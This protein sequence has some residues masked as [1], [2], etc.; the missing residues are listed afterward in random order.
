MENIG[1]PSGGP[2]IS[3][4]NFSTVAITGGRTIRLIGQRIQMGGGTLIIGPEANVEGIALQ[5]LVYGAGF[6]FENG[7]ASVKGDPE[8][9]VDLTIRG[10]D[11]LNVPEGTSL[12]VLEGVTLTVDG[13]LTVEGEL[14]GAGAIRVETGGS[15]TGTGDISGKVQHKLTED[16]VN[17]EKDSYTYTGE[18]ITPEV[19]INEYTQ[20]TDYMVTYENNTDAG[21]ATITITPTKTGKLYGEV[22][23]YFT[24]SQATPTFAEDDWKVESKTYDGEQISITVPALTGVNN[25]PI[26]EN[27]TLRYKVAGQ[28][29]DTY[30]EEAPT[31]VGEYVVKATFAGNDNY[32]EAETTAQFTI[33]KASATLEYKEAAITKQY[34]DAAFVN[35][36]TNESGVQVSYSSSDEMVATVDENGEVTIHAVGET[37]ITA[38]VNDPNYTGEATY[39]LEVEAGEVEISRPDEQEQTITL[40]AGGTAFTLT[41][42]ITGLP[43]SE[44][45]RKWKWVSSDTDIATVE[46]IETLSTRA[47]EVNTEIKSEALVTPVGEGT[48]TITVTYES[49]NYKGTLTYTVS[50]KAKEE[51][52]APKPDPQPDPTPLYYNIQFGDICEGVDASLSKGVVKEGN[53][54]SVYVEVE[55]GYD[56]ENLKVLFKRSLYGYWEEVEEGVQPGEYII[57]NVYTDIYVKVV[58]VEKIEIEEEPTGMSDI[59]GTKVYAQNGSLYVYTSQPQEVMIITMNGTILKRERQEGLR[60][61]SLPKGVYIICIGEERMKVRN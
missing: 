58:G 26:T 46:E 3:G 60:S 16:M 52:P 53:Q 30:T 15:I 12:T 8:L 9:P 41:A 54:V 39:T 25:E 43:D 20:D 42:T 11:K 50:V 37:T 22:T 5:S 44:Q 35:E 49:T 29:D 34:G 17:I 47:E 14:K 1:G 51:E 10:E 48:A 45:N 18:A 32:N 27:I 28:D 31:N 19:T 56:G 2:A 4:D 21:E 40:E 7:E 23:M 38:T 59:E 55:E 57:Y 6:V 61:Y 13:E 33:S 24:I 36:L